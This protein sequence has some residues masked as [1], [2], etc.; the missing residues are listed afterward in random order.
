[1]ARRHLA[2]GVGIVGLGLA[3]GIGGCVAKA[4][5]VDETAAYGDD[6]A[7]TEGDTEA[8]ASLHVGSS[9]GGALSPSSLEGGSLHLQSGPSGAL[10]SL[11]SPAGCV[12][13]T[14]GLGKV[15]YV[16]SDCTGPYG[17]I[18]LT[19]TVDVTYSSTG[20]DNLTLEFSA[21]NFQIN[22][23][24]LSTWTATAV[25]TASGTARSATWNASLAG[26]T[27]AGRSF[28]RT[29]QKD[30]SWTVGGTCLSVSGTSQGTVSG[31]DLKT[32]ITSYSR[33]E[34]ACPASGSDISIEDVSNGDEV[35]IKYN[36]GAS[37]T[38]TLTANGKADAINL[39]LACG[40]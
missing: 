26:T 13:E 15:T 2:T 37:A 32:T 28:S 20:A 34:G 39:V 18:H 3:V 16:Y 31:L 6:M 25:V 30:I 8:L 24:T 19:G 35:E 14:P 7:Q 9:T 38:V 17:L 33:C 29:N 11:L 10:I 21:T 22:K 4:G 23:A 36:G 40:L 12:T 1:M 27:G 5:T